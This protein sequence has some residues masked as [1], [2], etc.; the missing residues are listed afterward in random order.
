M[1]KTILFMLSIISVLAVMSVY[2]ETKMERLEEAIEAQ[3]LQITLD[4][5]LNGYITG[6][7]CDDCKNIRVT[8]TPDTLAIANNV[9]VPLIKARERAGKSAIVIFDAKKLTVN[10]IRWYN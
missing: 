5:S 10:R 1:K 9:T 7:I 6:A 3:R 8:I 4:D 2:A